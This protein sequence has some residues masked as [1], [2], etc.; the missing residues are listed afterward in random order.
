MNDPQ[1]EENEKGKRLVFQEGKMYF[2]RSGE[3]LFFLVVTVVMAVMGILHKI[4]MP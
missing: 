3:R 4:N 2:T 1:I